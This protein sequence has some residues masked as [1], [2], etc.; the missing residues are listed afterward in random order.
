LYAHADYKFG[1]LPVY[2]AKQIRVSAEGFFRSLI[3]V[4][5]WWITHLQYG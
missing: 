1:I 2:V 3:V 5:K 4:R